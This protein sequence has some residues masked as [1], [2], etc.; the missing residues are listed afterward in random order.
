[1]D[2]VTEAVKAD[3]D[4]RTERGLRKYGTGLGAAGLSERELLQHAYEE[5]LDLAQYLK[6]LLMEK[7]ND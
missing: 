6:A 2:S 7:T 1:M 5:A 3:L 4:K